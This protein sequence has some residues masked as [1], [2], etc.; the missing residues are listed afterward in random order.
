[1]VYKNNAKDLLKI[2]THSSLSVF[3]SRIITPAQDNANNKTTRNRKGRDLRTSREIMMPAPLVLLTPSIKILD[4]YYFKCLT[5]PPP[6]FVLYFRGFIVGPLLPTLLYRGTI[7]KVLV[8]EST[9][10]PASTASAACLYTCRPALGCMLAAHGS[11][12]NADAQ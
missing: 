8:L 4:D 1:M 10:V 12:Y 7:V 5:R 11:C 3:S 2:K 6:P 9:T